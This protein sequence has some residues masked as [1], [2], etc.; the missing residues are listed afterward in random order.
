MRI[1][2]TNIQC[3]NEW[4]FFFFS[5]TGSL[6]IDFV[7]L[8]FSLEDVDTNLLNGPVKYLHPP[9]TAFIR[10]SSYVM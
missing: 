4:N 10:V 8:V 2:T 1:L 5:E 7:V 3:I 6:Y 9:L